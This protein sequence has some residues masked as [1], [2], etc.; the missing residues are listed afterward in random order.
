MGDSLPFASSQFL[1]EL[2][3]FLL[4]SLA[5]VVLL[6]SWSAWRVYHALLGRL[7]EHGVLLL[8]WL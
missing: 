6:T 5:G 8:V 3:L 2:V 1:T 7:V 4:V